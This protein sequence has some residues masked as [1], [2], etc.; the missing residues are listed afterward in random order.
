MHMR[1]CVHHAMVPATS[2]ATSF[3][4]VILIT[5]FIFVN[6]PIHRCNFLLASFQAAEENQ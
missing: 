5:H 3:E 1:T 2:Q 6:K 4:P